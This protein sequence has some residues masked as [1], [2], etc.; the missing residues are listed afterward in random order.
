M[1]IGFLFG[2]LEGIIVCVIKELLH[3]PFG[4]TG[5]VGE[6]AN[7]LMTVA[8]ILIPSVVYRVKKG[9]KT[10]ILS[11]AIGVIVM[12]AVGLAVNRYINFPLFMGDGAAAAFETLWRFIVYFNLIKGVVISLLTCLLYKT[13]SRILHK[14]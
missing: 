4:T 9:L 14:F 11:L 1:L 5:G 12:T 8:Y 13:L 10:V 6:I 3:I 2:P 7:I